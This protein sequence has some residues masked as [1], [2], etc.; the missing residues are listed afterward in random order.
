VK[1][2]SDHPLP[3]LLQAGVRCTLNADD[4]LLFGAG[5]L[6]EYETAR[7]ALA[8]TDPQ[9]AETARVSVGSSGAPRALVEDAVTRIGNWLGS[10][11]RVTTHQP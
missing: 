3:L 1:S 5:L 2:L 7:S 11:D 6:E 8:L 4:P 10:P 9:L